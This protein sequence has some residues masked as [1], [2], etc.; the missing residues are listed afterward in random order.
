MI[1]QTIS[2]KSVTAE[3]MGTLSVFEAGRDVPFDIKR[4]SDIH[5]A[6]AGVQR[7]GHAHTARR[8]GLWCP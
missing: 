7:G 3:G 8:Q 2:M 1:I 5:G 4:I 6:P